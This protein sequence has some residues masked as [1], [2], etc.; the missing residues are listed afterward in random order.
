MIPPLAIGRGLPSI[1]KKRRKHE[2]D[3]LQ[4][5]VASFL[6]QNFPKGSCVVWYAVPNGSKREKKQNKKGQWYSPEGAKLKRMGVRAGVADIII[7]WKANDGNT[8]Y[9]ASLALE[10]KAKLG[11]LSPEQKAW[12]QEWMSIGGIYS[13]CRTLDAVQEELESNGLKLKARVM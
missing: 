4:I 1:G 9:I 7:H 13:I 3:D 6:E 5:T 10:L 8:D 2:E 12:A 11:S